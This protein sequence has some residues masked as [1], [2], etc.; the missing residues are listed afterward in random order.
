MRT[1]LKNLVLIVGA[2]G[3]SLTASATPVT[4]DLDGAPTSAVAVDFHSGGLFCKLTDCGITAKLN[5]Y[6]DD[7]SKPLD[8]GQSWDFDFF[9]LSFVGLGGGTGTISASLGFDAPT[10]AAVA[11][12]TGTGGFLTFLGLITGGN[13]TWQSPASYSLAD[14]TA[15]SV[16]F[17]NLSGLTVG[18]TTVSGRITLLQGPGATSVP[19][20]ESLGLLGIGLL[21]LGLARRQ[22]LKAKT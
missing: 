21:G 20:P 19:E 8:V 9:N 7:L 11:T 13:L 10:G 2:L 17:E 6:L 1:T 5:P 12:G 16:S 14:G 3:G 15:Y 4:F 22:K 18:S